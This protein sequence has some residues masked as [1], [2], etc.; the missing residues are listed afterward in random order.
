[1]IT[2]IVLASKFY[3]ETQDVVVNADISRFVVDSKIHKAFD[4]DAMESSLCKV[5]DFDLFVSEQQYIKEAA[6]INTMIAKSNEETQASRLKNKT[7]R[8]TKQECHSV[9][10]RESSNIVI[11]IQ[12]SRS[13]EF[14]S[15]AKQWSPPSFQ[16]DVSTFDLATL[17]SS[18]M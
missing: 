3:C 11:G 8:F 1:M 7:L 9:F 18:D 10:K 6:K 4:L 12:K 15:K 2:A 5:L 17:F 14:Y 16:S 13:Q